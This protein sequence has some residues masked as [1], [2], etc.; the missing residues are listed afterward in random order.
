[1]LIFASSEQ[2]QGKIFGAIDAHA[3][4][5]GAVSPLRLIAESLCCKV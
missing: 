4:R 3:R 5:L 2:S 1:M